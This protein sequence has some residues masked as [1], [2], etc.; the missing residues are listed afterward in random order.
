M[1]RFY[2]MEHP[3]DKLIPVITLQVMLY[4]T[5]VKSYSLNSLSLF[6]S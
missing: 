5:A 6:L 2:I 4:I 1:V 3:Q